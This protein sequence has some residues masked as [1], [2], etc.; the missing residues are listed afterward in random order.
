MES[1]IILLLLIPVAIYVIKYSSSHLVVKD[2]SKIHPDATILHIS[3]KEDNWGRR[4]HIKTIVEFTD[5]VEYHTYKCR[6]EPGF[7]YTKYI[8]DAEVVEQIIEKAIIAHKKLAAEHPPKSQS[9]A[10]LNS[11]GTTL[12]EA[13]INEFSDYP[14]DFLK[15]ICSLIRQWRKAQRPSCKHSTLDYLRALASCG[16]RMGHETALQTCLNIYEEKM[17]F[18]QNVINQV[19]KLLDEHLDC[20]DETRRAKLE[21]GV[22]LN[23]SLHRLSEKMRMGKK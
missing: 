14:Q 7:G 23:L 2:Y 8:V 13:I 17:L 16:E 15:T 18:D 20:T 10:P 22:L 4:K 5:G 12:P 3:H 11:T 19:L 21:E 1:L 9:G 6:S